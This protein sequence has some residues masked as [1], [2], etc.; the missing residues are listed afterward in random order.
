MLIAFHDEFLTEGDRTF[1]L[2]CF[3]ADR[4]H[5]KLLTTG[6]AYP[7]QTS[8]ASTESSQKSSSFIEC[9]YKLR[10]IDS[11]TK[12]SVA[13]RLQDRL[14]I[15]TFVEHEWSCEGLR[16]GQCILVTNC[17]IRT[18]DSEHDWLDD[19]GCSMVKG[20]VDEL[21]YD[22]SNTVILSYFFKFNF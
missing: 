19:R 22:D 16:T 20:L 5:E 9:F 6:L 13:I 11:S 7:F 3:Y 15:G 10:K 18:Q 21:N 17:V 12:K 14:K 1:A 4:R 2:K 8:I